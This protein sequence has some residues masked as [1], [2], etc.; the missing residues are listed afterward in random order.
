[1][2]NSEIKLRIATRVPILILFTFI[3]SNFK[4][5][6]EKNKESSDFD[7]YLEQYIH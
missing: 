1:M 7:I 6:G 2:R 5:S 4:K 3:K